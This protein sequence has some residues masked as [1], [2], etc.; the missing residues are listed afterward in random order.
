[1]KDKQLTLNTR[2]MLGFRLANVII[3]NKKTLGVTTGA[4]LSV[5]IGAK[6]SVKIGSKIGAKIGAKVG[7]K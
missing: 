1:M 4:K 6:L 5:K 2:K 3:G 7:R